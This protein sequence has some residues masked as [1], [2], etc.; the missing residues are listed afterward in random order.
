MADTVPTWRRIGRWFRGGAAPTEAPDA[1][2]HRHLVDAHTRT[3]W[4]RG[5]PAPTTLVEADAPVSAVGRRRV[6]ALLDRHERGA[7]APRSGR[8]RANPAFSEAVFVELMRARRYDRAFELL[9]PD[10]QRTWGSSEHFTDAQR[11]GALR[12]LQGATVKAVKHLEAWTDPDTGTTHTHVAE[13]TVEYT[14]DNGRRSLV[15]DRTVHLVG[16]AGQWRSLCY[17]ESVVAGA[18]LRT[19]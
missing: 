18:G 13:L 12:H 3:F 11:G 15:V 6:S 10:C 4:A 8:P 7:A 1:E 14:L 19:S 5:A 9:A 2:P 17:P 16:V